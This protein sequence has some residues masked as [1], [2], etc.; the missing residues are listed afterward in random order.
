[1]LNRRVGYR[2]ILRATPAFLTSLGSHEI[3]RIYDS[4]M[5]GHPEV[6]RKRRWGK[7]SRIWTYN[8]RSLSEEPR[9]VNGD[10]CRNREF[11][12]L[13]IEP[14][15]V[16][17]WRGVPSSGSMGFESLGVADVWI[18]SRQR[19]ELGCLRVALRRDRGG[20][21]EAVSSLGWQR[22]SGNEDTSAGR[23]EARVSRRD[24]GQCLSGGM[25]DGLS[26]LG[27]EGL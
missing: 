3:G 27:V 2:P 11:G 16:S 13:L 6:G 21:P 1:M 14:F 19:G 7:L 22:F 4:R 26:Y 24:V 18:R 12:A 25:N 9:G 20:L 23:A 8:A 5:V 15:E 10:E 17:R